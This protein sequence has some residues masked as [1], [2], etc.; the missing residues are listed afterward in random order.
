M[1][2]V[3]HRANGAN[4]ISVSRT[5]RAVRWIAPSRNR[6]P[7]AAEPAV[8]RMQAAYRA[9]KMEMPPVRGTGSVEVAAAV[10]EDGSRRQATMPLTPPAS[11]QL[12]SSGSMSRSGRQS[13]PDSAPRHCPVR[14]TA[15]KWSLLRPMP[16]GFGE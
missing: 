15:T 4:V 3:Q 7:S 16:G 14:R 9:A 1:D 12:L 6:M 8:S 10:S 5:G 13:R 11:G 2:T